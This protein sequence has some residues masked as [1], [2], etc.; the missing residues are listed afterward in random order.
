LAPIAICA[1]LSGACDVEKKDTSTA[2]APKPAGPATT[3]T[4]TGTPSGPASAATGTLSADFPKD[5]P[6]YTGA[7]I[8]GSASVAG[9]HSAALTTD[10]ASD[11]VA[12]FYKD[13][14][15]RNGWTVPDAMTAAGNT[16][17][18]ATKDK[19]QCAVTIAKGQDGKTT[20]ALSITALP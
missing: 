8:T 5:V 7:T 6:I 2:S 3:T 11:K 10:D 12:T 19:Q 13:E 1:L 4:T 17:L 9:T 15:K 18:H 20:I 14:L 16:V